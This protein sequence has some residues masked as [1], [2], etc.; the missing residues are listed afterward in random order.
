MRRP[1]FCFIAMLLPLLRVY[2]QEATLNKTVAG[3]IISAN[4]HLPVAGA[5]LTLQYAK[6][7]AVTNDNGAFSITRTSTTDTLIVSHI[8]YET[9]RIAVNENTTTLLIVLDEALNQV[10]N[11]VVSTGYENLP[12]ERATGS[13]YKVNS[14]ILN[15][16]VSTDIISK[17][18]GITSGLVFNKDAGG[19]TILNIRGQNTIFANASP[20]IVVDNFPYEGDINNINPNDIKS[21]TVLKDAAAASIWGVRA[22]N[23]VI[24]IT[25]QK[26]EF[27]EPLNVSINANITTSSDPNLF[28]NP[29]FLDSKDFINIEKTLFNQGF[30]DADLSSAIYVPVSP[31]VAILNQQREGQISS[32]E[33]D[34]QINALQNIDIRNELKKYFYQKAIDQQY[35]LN[36]NGGGE[37]YSYH[38]SAAYDKDLA[39]EKFSKYHR[40]SISSLNTFKPLKS[41]EI[42]IGVIYVQSNNKFDNTL[43]EIITG[44]PRG[45]SIYPYAAFKDNNGNSLSIVKDYSTVFVENAEANGFLNWQFYPLEEIGLNTTNIKEGDT[46]ITSGIKYTL[47]PGLD[48]DFK[49]LYENGVN[50]QQNLAKQN[51]YYVRNLINQYASVTDGQVTN[52][53]N[54]PSGDILKTTNGNLISNNF[55][56]Q[57]NYNNHWH[58]NLINAIGGIEVRQIGNNSSSNTLYGY[59]NDKAIS[60]LIDPLTYFS[61]YPSGMSMPIPM[62]IGITSTLNRFRSYFTNASYSY[63]ER[64]TVSVSGRIDQSNLFGVKANQRSVPLWSSGLKWDVSKE[65]FYH[66]NWLSQLSL[67]ATYGFNGNIDK[68]QTAFTTADYLSFALFTGLPYANILSPPNPELQWEKTSMVN[69]GVD[70]SIKHDLLTGS[71][72][73]FFKRGND[74]IGDDILAPSTGYV[75]PNT[76]ANTFRGNFAN[77]KGRGL[78]VAITSKNIDRIFKWTTNFLFSYATD[79]VTHFGVENPAY[80]AVYYGDGS[81]GLLSPIKGRPVYSVYSFKWAGLDPSTGDPRGYFEGEMSEDY[82]AILNT[83]QQEDIVYEGPARPTFFGGV[84]NSFSWNGFS[85][86]VNISYKLGYYFKRSSISYD[87]LYNSWNANKDFIKRWEKAGDE[88]NTNVPS[89]PEVDNPMRDGFYLN[90]QTLVE[91]GD[92]IRLQDISLSYSFNKDKF[93]KIPFSQL[94]LY[95]YVNNLGIIWRANKQGIDPDYP[96]GGIPD[97]KTISIGLKADF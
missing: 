95:L 48:I 82:S 15:K 1:L 83:S 91:K 45:K 7:Y 6:K 58:K 62:D 96:K 26:G 38:F 30:Y 2:A 41:L 43:S 56:A 32:T 53:S 88:N 70:F 80:Y 77:M 69:I 23:G 63:N 39:N 90:S 84:N 94:Q 72:E 44:G 31:V 57:I 49:Y 46:R 75:N 12:K 51:S 24:V 34:A 47:I 59:D 9:K 65:Q 60:Q 54:I 17:L 27:N 33:A 36:V 93:P 76:G 50:Q 68:S 29:N 67:R 42:N 22:G 71:L 64:Y 11:I 28:Y 73:Y 14:E 20:L 37:K 25:T 8:S 85:L 55:R 40:I 79:R 86:W 87:G 3:K 81:S 35:A 92:H 18:N 89:M 61:L 21:I 16:R 13:F 19:N 10:N 78:D 66:I 97:P 4:G 74:L 5:A 52:I